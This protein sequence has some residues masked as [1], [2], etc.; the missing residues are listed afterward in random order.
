M[1]RRHRDAA[2]QTNYEVTMR[3]SWI[4]TC[5]LL[6][7]PTPLLFPSIL[8]ASVLLASTAFAE[9]HWP[10]FRGPSASGIS[11]GAAMPETWDVDSGENVVWK[12]AIPGLG[13]SSPIVWGD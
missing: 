12:T 7:P 4:T 2:S 13:V 3:P 10:S 9:A 11:E 8:L 1:S 5:R 6:R